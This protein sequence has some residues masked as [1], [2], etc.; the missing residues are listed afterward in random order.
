MSALRAASSSPMMALRSTPAEVTNTSNGRACRNAWMPPR[1]CAAH[2][3]ARA[4][5]NRAPLEL[6]THVDTASKARGAPARK[7]ARHAWPAQQP[8]DSPQQYHWTR[9]LIVIRKWMGMFTCGAAYNATW[10]G[11]RYQQHHAT[12]GHSTMARLYYP[13][14]QALPGMLLPLPTSMGGCKP[15]LYL[16]MLP[17]PKQRPRI[18]RHAGTLTACV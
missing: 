6:F 16:L 1:I 13:R 9:Y 11:V 8:R 12:V 10:C 7:H 17:I 4:G 5:Q 18:S 15:F 14:Q 2:Q 3:H